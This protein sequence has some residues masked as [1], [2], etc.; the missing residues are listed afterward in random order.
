MDVVASMHDLTESCERFLEELYPYLHMTPYPAEAYAHA[1]R[2]V[3]ERMIRFADDHP[4][5]VAMLRYEDLVEAPEET[6]RDVFDFLDEPWDPEIIQRAMSD[7]GEIG[8]GDWKTYEAAHV[9]DKSVW[10]WQSLSQSL[11]N[12]AAPVINDTLRTLGYEMVPRK[13][14]QTTD[15]AMSW[16]RLIMM[17]KARQAK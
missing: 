11:L 10:R 1:W 2:S 9:H 13:E 12:R 8:L 5:A 14:P 7:V 3:C 4:D 16:Y 15:E 17:E 6:L